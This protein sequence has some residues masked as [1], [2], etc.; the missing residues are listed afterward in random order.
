MSLPELI[1][2]L[3]HADGLLPQLLL[4][5]LRPRCAR[6]GLR[7]LWS[8]WRAG[9]LPAGGRK[10]T[11]LGIGDIMEAGEIPR[12]PEMSEGSPNRSR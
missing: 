7:A 10:A 4:A 8:P 6:G 2:G 11:Q 3:T 9:H 1:S 5:G 12:D